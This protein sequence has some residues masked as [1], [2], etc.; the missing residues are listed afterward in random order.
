MARPR[1]AALNRELI[2]DQIELAFADYALKDL[3][4]AMISKVLG[5]KPPSLYAHFSSFDEVKDEL[6][7]RALMKMKDTLLIA[8]SKNVRKDTL[9]SFMFAYRDLASSN[10]LLFDCAQFGIRNDN[11]KLMEL[12]QE[13]VEIA[14]NIFKER[15]FS[16]EKAIHQVRIVR[17]LLNGFILTE[18][19]NG[20][21]RSESLD[22]TFI[23]LVK[24]TEKGLEN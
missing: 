22:K 4:L 17:S 16:G 20:F 2:L 9:K 5:I 21:Q 24:F 15:G 1:G 14:L 18:R 23:E 8:V 10:P 12:A 6:T 13:I 11:E 7:A 3:S 19:E